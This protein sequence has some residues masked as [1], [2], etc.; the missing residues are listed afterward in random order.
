MGLAAVS[1][2]RSEEKEKE[3]SLRT[4]AWLRVNGPLLAWRGYGMK[5]SGRKD[6]TAQLD[7]QRERQRNLHLVA[8]TAQH[9]VGKVA[10]P[11]PG[12]LLSLNYCPA[13]AYVEGLP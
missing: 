8:A 11:S 2:T 5:T 13:C 10:R 7:T 12:C 9:D 4:G 1:R 3:I 6:L